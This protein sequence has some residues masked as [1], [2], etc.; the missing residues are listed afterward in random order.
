M[1][2]LVNFIAS[3]DLA[4][5]KLEKVADVFVKILVVDGAFCKV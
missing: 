5:L 3:V 2:S 4:S 1:D